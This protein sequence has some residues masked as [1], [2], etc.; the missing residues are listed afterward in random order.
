[1]KHLIGLSQ[2]ASCHVY[3]SYI[4]SFSDQILSLLWKQGVKRLRATTTNWFPLG[5]TPTSR[6][7]MSK[8][9]I[10]YLTNSQI[11][12]NFKEPNSCG[13]CNHWSLSFYENRFC[14]LA[15]HSSACRNYV[16]LY[17]CWSHGIVF[18]CKLSFCVENIRRSLRLLSL[19]NFWCRGL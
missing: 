15:L 8:S 17:E 11:W 13:P 12:G 3:R 19:I 14:S 4:V 16:V 5:L 18:W 6:Y 7:H 10:S 2:L 9:D 1:M